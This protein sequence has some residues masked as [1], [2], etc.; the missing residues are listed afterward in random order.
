M[1]ISS[2]LM[3]V[4]VAIALTLL[5]V[6]ALSMVNPAAAQQSEK[7]DQL[8]RLKL[9]QLFY[10]PYY[11]PYPQV[12]R[13]KRRKRKRVVTKKCAFPWSYSRGLRKCIC[14]RSDYAVHEGNCV[15]IAEICPQNSQWSELEKKCRCDGG[16]DDVGGTCVP[17]SSG[18]AE[19]NPGR[20]RTVS[21]APRTIGR[22][23]GL[24]LRSGLSRGGRYVCRGRP[25]GPGAEEAHNE[26]RAAHG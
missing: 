2:G 9:A 11:Y 17:A 15:K 20:Q 5:A 19:Y 24:Q 14:V 1:A 23:R 10:Q 7:P 3:R 6:L 4:R 13:K 8:E 22:W 18:T 26:R 16:F 25:T 21:V 12:R